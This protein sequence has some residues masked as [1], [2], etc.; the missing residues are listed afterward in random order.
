MSAP[1][2]I[3]LDLLGTWAFAAYG[4]HRAK[5][6][7]FDLFG[8]TTI[9]FISGLGGGTVRDLF[10]N[11]S[12][13]Y[14]TKP[15]Y[16]LVVLLGVAFALLPVTYF[17]KAKRAMLVVDAI[18]LVAFA[19]LGAEIARQSGYGL[20]GSMI[21]ATMTACGGSVLRDISM[22]RTPELFYQD[23]YATPALLLGAIHFFLRPL[24]FHWYPPVLLLLSIFLIRLLAIRFNVQ[25]WKPTR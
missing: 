3:F 6:L 14:L 4:A 12:P 13:A 1:M 18:G 17:N 11:T 25:L 19:Y 20:L 10:L 21:F 2:P 22:N 24:L 8:I 7:R 23:F 5:Q 15:I 9:A 16:A